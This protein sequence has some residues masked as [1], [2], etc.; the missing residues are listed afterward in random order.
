MAHLGTC[1]VPLG[2]VDHVFSSAWYVDK[3]TAAVTIAPVNTLCLFFLDVLQDALRTIDFDQAGTTN[4]FGDNQL[5]ADLH[6]DD[7]IFRNLRGCS[8]VAAASSEEQP[9]IIP[10]GGEGYNVSATAVGVM[11]TW[12][13]LLTLLNAFIK[14]SSQLSDCPSMTAQGPNSFILDF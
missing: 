6:A 12:L 3:S 10:L 14:L 7:I 1:T 13:T 11:L 8:A 9:E 2:S 4:K 5:Q